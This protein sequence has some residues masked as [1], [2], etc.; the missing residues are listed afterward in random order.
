MNIWPQELKEL[1]KREFEYNPETGEIKRVSKRGVKKD[2]TLT[3]SKDRNGFRTVGIT[4]SGKYY[5]V[6]LHRI[7]WFLATGQ[8]NTFVKFLESQDDF[9]LCN[10]LG[11][12]KSSS[13]EKLEQ[14]ETGPDYSMIYGTKE[15]WKRLEHDMNK[16]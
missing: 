1:I 13:L 7:C 3:G 16:S 12:E 10:L 8:E 4:C 11:Y 2:K 9:R 15:D 5:Q 6:K 14:E